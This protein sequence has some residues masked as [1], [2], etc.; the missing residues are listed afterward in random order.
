MTVAPQMTV[1]T[2]PLDLS[3]YDIPHPRPFLCDLSVMQR[4]LSG[5]V[6]HV[7]NVQYVRWLDRAAEL[8]ADSLGFTRAAL[9]EKGIMW[10]VA[11]H[12]VDYVGE[13][14]RDD[15][16]VIATWVR[17]ARRVKSWR[18]YL[19]VR[20]RDEKVLCRASTLWV[21]VNLATRKPTRLSPAMLERFDALET[22]HVP[23]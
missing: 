2:A 4:E 9:L 18:D 19:V 5:I 23:A 11:R 1:R 20:P 15:Q 6:E 10:F 8:H 14:M 13:A 21:L 22:P 3:A 12:E 7:S 17:D 16:L